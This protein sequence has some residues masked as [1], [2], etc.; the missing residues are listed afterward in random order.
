MFAYIYVGIALTYWL[1][2]E[3]EFQTNPKPKWNRFQIFLIGLFWPAIVLFVIV[4]VVW[5]I[6]ADTMRV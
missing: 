3:I 2:W 5:N 4:F 1:G 6:I